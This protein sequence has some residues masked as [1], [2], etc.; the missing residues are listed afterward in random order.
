MAGLNADRECG[1]K[2]NFSEV[3]R[4]YGADGHT[5]SKYWNGG[6]PSPD[7]GRHGRQS[8]FDR[9]RDEIEEKAALPGATAKGT[10]ELLLERHAGD[11]PPVPGHNAFTSH[12]RGRGIAVGRG[13][14]P[15][16]HPRFGTAPGEQLQSDWKEGVT[17]RD[18]SGRGYR[19]DAYA[20]TLGWSRMH[21]FVRSPTRARDDL[22]ACMA[23]DI[24]WL[25]GVPRQR[26]ADNVPAV[27]TLG[28]DG[29]RSRDGRVAAFARE[30]GLGLALC[31]PRTPQT[32]GRDEGASRLLSR[33]GACEGDFEGWEG[34]DRA[35]ARVRA[36]SNEEPNRTTGLPPEPL[37][38]R[39]RGA[40]GP[41][42]RESVPSALVGGV[43]WQV[44]PA[45]MLVR[46]AGREFPVPRGC[47]GR[48]VRL[49]L[50]PGGRL[51]A[52]DGGGLVAAHDAAAPGGPVAY[53]EG[54]CAEAVA[55]ERWGGDAD[56]E[57]QARRN[58]ELL[59]GPGG[60]EGS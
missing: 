15:D 23:D 24:R 6:G 53:R 25:G 43:P 57:A 16:A 59:G 29:R 10:H 13:G 55:D 58:L 45:T 9:C 40:L 54:D 48:R 31:R 26:L 34:L 14:A 35:M 11:E 4:R 51:R 33:L 28:G 47:M 42:P 39:E 50:E 52:Y 46:C 20:S 18:R 37:F 8:G 60:G 36:R 19:F 21:H 32:K 56:I 1:V 49:L 17:M 12:L 7:D 3:A 44:V 38:R 5:V 27:A 41:M 2:P 22:L 30:A